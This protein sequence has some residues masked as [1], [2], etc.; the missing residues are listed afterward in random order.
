MQFRVGLG[1]RGIEPLLHLREV[2]LRHVALR[3]VE[4]VDKRQDVPGREPGWLQARGGGGLPGGS[5][6][7]PQG[8]QA[9][10]VL[11]QSSKRSVARK[12]M[13]E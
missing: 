6:Q 11:K 7:A 3:Q 2:L 4:A 8:G 10:Y 5:L 9:T 13:M 1:L 12:P